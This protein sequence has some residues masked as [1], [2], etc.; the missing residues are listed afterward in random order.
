MS[1]FKWSKRNDV[2]KMKERIRYIRNIG[3]EKILERLNDIKNQ[4]HVPTDILTTILNNWSIC[5]A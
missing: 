1:K 3:K 2:K 5:Q 4:N